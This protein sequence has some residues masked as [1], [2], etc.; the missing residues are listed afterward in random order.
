[1]KHVLTIAGSD[2]S[3]GA[4]IQ[5]DLKTMCALGVYGMTAITALTIQNTREVR[6]VDAVSPDTVK[7]QIAAVYDDIRVDAV[8]IGMVV[9][10]GISATISAELLGRKAKNIVLD[11]VM[12]SKSGGRLIDD[13]AVQETMRLAPA[14]VVIT[15]NIKEAELLSGMRI[16]HHGDMETAAKIIQ[17]HG[18]INILIKGGARETDADD[19]LLLGKERI[20]LRSDRVPTKNLH[21]AGCTLSSAIACFLAKGL[22]VR[23]AV[24]AAKDYVHQAIR[25]SL[26]VGGGVGPLGHLQA[27][28]RRTGEVV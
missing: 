10:A 4:G 13:D 11:P 20:W 8:K 24:E 12:V 3:G 15:P 25:D 22:K 23:E 7:G 17:D 26:T 28:Y 21:G 9:N 27:L 5:A 14:A 2:P 19:Y 16:V 1:M 6:G 18:A